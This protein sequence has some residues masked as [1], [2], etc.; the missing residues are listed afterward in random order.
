LSG[1]HFG[2]TKDTREEGSLIAVGY[3]VQWR[4]K[5]LP[6]LPKATMEYDFMILFLSLQQA[7]NCS[8]GRDERPHIV[9]ASEDGFFPILQPE[10]DTCW[11]MARKQAFRLAEK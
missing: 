11:D 3:I 9:W 6:W 8:L 10:A 2:S 7:E 1:K 4:M 5:L